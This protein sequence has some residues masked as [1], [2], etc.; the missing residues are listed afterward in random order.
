MF[1]CQTENAYVQ[2]EHKGCRSWVYND[3]KQI[4][5]E[6]TKDLIKKKKV[7]NIIRQFIKEET[8]IANKH[9]KVLQPHLKSGKY[10]KLKPQWD[11]F[12]NQKLTKILKPQSF[13]SWKNMKTMS[14]LIYP[15]VIEVVVN[16]V[17]VF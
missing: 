3:G 9:I 14:P 13:K 4:N 5:E 17:P 2:A 10:I 7:K 12:D 11:S 15:W 16:L 1:K 6:N 8:K